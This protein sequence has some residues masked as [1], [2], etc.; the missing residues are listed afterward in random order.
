VL[1]LLVIVALI[2]LGLLTKRYRLS[3]E[4]ARAGVTGEAKG[5][6]KGPSIE[7]GVPGWKLDMGDECPSPPD[8]GPPK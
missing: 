2:E 4:A 1:L 6:P 7:G 5:G 3:K 8:G